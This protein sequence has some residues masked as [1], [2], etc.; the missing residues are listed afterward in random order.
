MIILLD[1]GPLGMITNPKPSAENDACTFWLES[2]LQIGT[3]IILPEIAD[4]EV[5]RELLRAK[6]FV[7]I[8]RLDAMQHILDYVPLT[9]ETMRKAA[10]FWAIAR[11]QG[12]PA[13]DAKALDSDMILAAQAAFFAERDEEVVI[14][15]TNVKHLAM[16]A[17]AQLWQEI[18]S[19]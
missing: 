3:R 8:E 18:Q 4:Y 6:K 17:K 16:F 12:R 2:A 13:A 11:N 5:R 14:A 9:T 19:K 10:E 1:A 7:G 15:T